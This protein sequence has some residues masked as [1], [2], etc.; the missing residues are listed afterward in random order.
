M[1]CTSSPIGYSLLPS[2]RF[3]RPASAHR[4]L[5]SSSFTGTNFSLPPGE[6]F[7]GLASGV[8][9]ELPLCDS[10]SSSRSSPRSGSVLT[11]RMR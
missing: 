3:I 11:R 9:C 5:N 2:R 6:T 1:S 8:R 10:H 7:D 4:D